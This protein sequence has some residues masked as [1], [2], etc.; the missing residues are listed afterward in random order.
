M[1]DLTSNQICNICRI[2]YNT[3]LRCCA[4]GSNVEGG[5]LFAKESSV[6]WIVA[7]NAYTVSRSWYCRNDA[8]TV[9]EASVPCGDWFVPNLSE[10]LY[11]SNY[12]EFWDT[13]STSTTSHWVSSTCGTG[14]TNSSSWSVVVCRSCTCATFNNN[15]RTVRALRRVFY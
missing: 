13:Y 1:A 10:L 12:K 3:G 14:G 15:A 4:L 8:V 5:Y 9:V 7:P 11:A 6:A 2:H